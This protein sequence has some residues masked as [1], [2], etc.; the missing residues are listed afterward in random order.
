MENVIVKEESK[1]NNTFLWGAIWLLFVVTELLFVFPDWDIFLAPVFALLTSYLYFKEDKKLLVAVILVFGN[2][3]LGTL[4]LGSISTIYLIFLF[5]AYEIIMQKKIEVRL[6]VIFSLASI[7]AL[8]PCF[9]DVITFKS[10]LLT[11]SYIALFFLVFQEYETERE[12]LEEI[13]FSILSIVS[14]LSLHMLITGGVI[15]SDTADRAGLIGVGVGDANYSAL[16]LCIGISSVLNYKK[17]HIAWRIATCT[18]MIAAM[19]ETLSI[20]G[21][22]GLLIVVIFSFSLNKNFGKALFRVILILLILV[23]LFQL[24]TVLPDRFHVEGIDDYILRVEEKLGFA[25]KGDYDAV[26]TDRTELSAFKVNYFLN[27]TPL[28]R[29]LFGFNALNIGDGFMSHNTYVDFLLQLGIIGTMLVVAYI[30]VRAMRSFKL[31]R[32]EEVSHKYIFTLKML[33]LFFA[34]TISIYQGHIFLIFL[35]ACFLF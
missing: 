14:L 31:F 2:D 13:K 17:L 24:Y 20:S 1:R 16:I 34:F 6:L 3:A 7:V 23:L 29:Q 33:F 18:V 15:V 9:T 12:F 5:L 8:M 28:F 4:L 32:K 19:V 22:I 27:Q 21:L 30:F 35:M 11:V 10:G 26:T 25:E